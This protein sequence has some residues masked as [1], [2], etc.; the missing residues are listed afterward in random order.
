M[1]FPSM[2][3]LQHKNYLLL[4]AHQCPISNLA[5]SEDQTSFFTVGETDHM[6]LEW[7]VK[8]HQPS[9]KFTGKEQKDIA[10]ESAC[11]SFTRNLLGKEVGQKRNSSLALST[12]YFRGTLV[13]KLNRRLHDTLLLNTETLDEDEASLM[14][15]R[16]KAHLALS[17]VY[18]FEADKCHQIRYMSREG[19]KADFV[20]ATS[21]FIVERGEETKIYETAT[22]IAFFA[23]NEWGEHVYA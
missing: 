1:Y 4:P 12:Y 2:S 14:K 21:R 17:T 20:Y 18:G 22:E 16:S 19:E 11:E 15:R 7:A 8:Q 3:S 13:D 10:L 9:P 6:L 23:L 5:I